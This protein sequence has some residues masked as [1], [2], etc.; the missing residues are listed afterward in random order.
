MCKEKSYETGWWQRW[1]WKRSNRLVQYRMNG[2]E[3]CLIGVTRIG[4]WWA[5]TCL[6][7]LMTS[8][9]HRL[10]SFHAMQVMMGPIVIV[11]DM[12]CLA[13]FIFFFGDLNFHLWKYQTWYSWCHFPQVFIEPSIQGWCY[14]ETHRILR[15][16]LK[17]A[18][19]ISLG[20][21]THAYDNGSILE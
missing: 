1:R 21:V 15:E 8:L 19:D 10:I 6:G 18:I 5:R 3:E 7:C 2:W 17:R 4:I 11:V 16:I 13:D 14:M 9:T 20:H 12:S